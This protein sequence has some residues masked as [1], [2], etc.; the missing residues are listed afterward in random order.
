MK[1]YIEA[2]KAKQAWLD[3]STEER[4]AYADQVGPAVQQMIADGAE[5]ISWGI[6]DADTDNR[7]DFDF[8]SIFKFPSDEFAKTFEGMVNAA[9]WYTYFDQVNIKSSPGTPQDVIAKMIAL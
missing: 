1:F 3:L 9:G 7:L 5:V 4:T 2:W 6:N 8:M